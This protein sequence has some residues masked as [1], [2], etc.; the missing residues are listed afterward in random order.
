MPRKR[1]KLELQPDLLD[2]IVDG[3]RQFGSV[4]MAAHY[5]G[6]DDQTVWN[7]LNRAEKDRG[8]FAELA[9]KARQAQMEFAKRHLDNITRAAEQGTWQAA[10][11][12]LERTLPDIY[13]RY[14]P[15]AKDTNSFAQDW[16]QIIMLCEEEMEGK[17][18]NTP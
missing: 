9:T 1:T 12:I 3:F 11:W 10:A 14:K 15:Q 7:Y 16:R 17:E 18:A 2:R 8:I 13:G 4:H 5:A 6:L